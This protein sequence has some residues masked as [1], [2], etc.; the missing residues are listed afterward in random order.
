MKLINELRALIE[1]A[2][3]GPWSNAEGT[4]EHLLARALLDDGVTSHAVCEVSDADSEVM[5]PCS[6]PRP[7]CWTWWRRRRR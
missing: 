7:R 6:T 4:P 2:P 1:R 3:P 5:S